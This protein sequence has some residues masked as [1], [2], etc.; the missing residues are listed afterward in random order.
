MPELMTRSMQIS[1]KQVEAV[2]PELQE[3]AA[4]LQERIRTLS[5]EKQQ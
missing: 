1:E 5:H 2:M 3:S 4:R